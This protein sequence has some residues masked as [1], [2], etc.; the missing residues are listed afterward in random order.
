MRY[1]QKWMVIPYIPPSERENKQNNLDSN[2]SI[3]L[4]KETLPDDI[5]IKEY[6]QQLNKNFQISH[7]LI[8]D[9]K[10][11]NSESTQS[12]TKIPPTSSNP[13]I[14]NQKTKK[15]IVK[16]LQKKQSKKSKKDFEKQQQLEQ[17]HQQT[18]EQPQLLNE[19]E[20]QK[21]IS[22]ENVQDEHEE[23]F[24]E[25]ENNDFFE[26]KPTQ[27]SSPLKKRKNRELNNLLSNFNNSKYDMLD[28][29]SFLDK[30]ETT[31]RST[32]SFKI[33]SY[34]LKLFHFMK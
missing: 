24:S 12:T 15:V 22:R 2:L 4:Q 23:F 31:T 30:D 17:T 14:L 18:Q 1:S 32:I 6:N 28:R 10:I 21:Q 9:S 19:S 26:S 25:S 20:P 34:H 5:K 33:I 27:T 13:Q 8:P 3:V 11:T 29:P 7:P 16:S